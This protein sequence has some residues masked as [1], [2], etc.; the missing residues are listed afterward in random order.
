MFLLNLR[1]KLSEDENIEIVFHPLN[2]NNI[3]CF[4]A[5]TS[6]KGK[7]LNNTPKGWIIRKDPQDDA[8]EGQPKHYHCKK[9]GKDI[10]ITQDGYGSHKTS[11]GDLIP[12]KLA[13]YLI[14]ECDIPVKKDANGGYVIRFEILEPRYSLRENRLQEFYEYI[15]NNWSVSN[16]DT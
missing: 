16:I 7:Y 15:F 6:G 3:L 9:D 11:K 8:F 1:F 2:S 13:D 5:R 10:V 14:K 12:K 4:A